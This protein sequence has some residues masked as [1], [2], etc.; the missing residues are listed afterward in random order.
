MLLD[1]LQS[2]LAQSQKNRDQVKV[3]TLRFLLGAVFNLQ[4]EKCP[5]GSGKVLEDA[6]VLSVIARQVKTHNESIEMFGQGGREDLVAKEKAELA[7]LQA[8]L[9]AQMPETEIREQIAKIKAANPNADF[10]AL[11]KLCVAQLRGKADGSLIAE[12]ARH[13]N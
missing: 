7:I 4:I 12:Y 9:P 2:D 11:M 5:P 8:Y 3:D 10:G 13:S 1:Q 6:D